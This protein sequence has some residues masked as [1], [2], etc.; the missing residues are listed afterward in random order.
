LSGAWVNNG[1]AGTTSNYLAT[2]LT[3]SDLTVIGG[4]AS[5]SASLSGSAAA[6]RSLAAGTQTGTLFGSYLFQKTTD[7]NSNTVGALLI[8]G[9]ATMN[10]TAANFDLANNEFGTDNGGLRLTN[11][12]AALSGPALSTGI[13]YL[14]AFKIDGVG[15]SS[16]TLTAWILTAAQYDT[17]KIGGITTA[18]LDANNTE[19][20]T[21]TKLQS[22][23]FTNGDFLRLFNYDGAS[24]TL[25]TSFD[26]LKISNS[27]INEAITAI[28]EP[29]TYALVLGGL[30]MLIGMGRRTI[31]SRSARV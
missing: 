1:D 12:G 8:G 21:T 13:T 25:V 7:A 29:S 16:Q 17:V 15:G 24:S 28:P 3:F 30:A 20:G 22:G 10:D 11:S 4:A 18:K 31:R 5:E 19:P 23:T 2:G 6:A 14:M 27:S 9:S 26:E